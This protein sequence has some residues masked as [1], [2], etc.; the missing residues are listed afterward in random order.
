MLEK[1]YLSQLALDGKHP[2]VVALLLVILMVGL[3][4]LLQPF[5]HSAALLV[6]IGRAHV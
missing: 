1:F 5:L 6:Q 4:F 2:Y 3:R